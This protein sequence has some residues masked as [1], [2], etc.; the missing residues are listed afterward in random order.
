MTVLISCVAPFVFGAACWMQP[1][2]DAPQAVRSR[3]AAGQ[4]ASAGAGVAVARPDDAIEVPANLTD[5]P[6]DEKVLMSTVR[7]F[8]QA[9]NAGDATKL[10]TLFTDDAEIVDENGDRVSGRENLQEEYQALF[11]ESPR[12]TIKV[13]VQSLRFL[14]DSTAQEEGQTRI[15]PSGGGPPSVRRYTVLYIKQGGA[16]KY[17]SVREEHDSTL[18]SR[19][20]LQELAWL[21]GDWIDEDP[22]AVVHT[23]CDW[24]PDGNF[25]LRDFTVHIQGKPA[26]TVHERI[27]WDPLAKQVRSW[28]FDS[29]GGFGGGLWTREGDR[30]IIKS[31]G[32][33]S[34]G[35]VASATHEIAK[36]NAQQY[37]WTARDR[38]V[39]GRAELEKEEFI[40]VR[41][42]P[43]PESFGEK[44]R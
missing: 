13:S 41:Q 2:Q 4:A 44:N 22:S 37:R 29:E 5:R 38:V 21:I 33:V 40:L 15:F 25:L 20:H 26:M 7:A 18:L 27:G 28:V 10:A 12:S 34:D 11:E 6:E 30:W 14:G 35:K 32:V 1:G 3:P 23:H 39:G 8:V 43:R 31:S 36:L 24:S 17:A 19:E 16:W 42:P 9:F